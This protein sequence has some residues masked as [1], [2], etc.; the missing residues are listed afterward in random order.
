MKCEKK[1]RERQGWDRI[2]IAGKLV[3]LFSQFLFPFFI[4][5]NNCKLIYVKN[6]MTKDKQT[7]FFIK[8]ILGFIF[9]WNKEYCYD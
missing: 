5:F 4:H 3:S 1:K 7:N 6:K 8:R 9:S 2:C